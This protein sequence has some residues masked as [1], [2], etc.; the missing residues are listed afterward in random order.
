[1]ELTLFV[2]ISA[3]RLRLGRPVYALYAISPKSL[4]IAA[5]H[6]GLNKILINGFRVFA[7]VGDAPYRRR[8]LRVVSQFLDGRQRD[9][10]VIQTVFSQVAS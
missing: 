4:H 5:V 10:F 3:H 8:S 6:H 7:G 2:G 9:Q 1:M